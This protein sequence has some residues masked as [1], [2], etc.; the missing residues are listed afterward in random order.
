[1]ELSDC[2]PTGHS[3][4]QSVVVWC[5]LWSAG[6]TEPDGG[7][8]KHGLGICEICTHEICGETELEQS[9]HKV[10]IVV[11]AFLLQRSHHF[12]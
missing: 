10:Y 5:L 6:H 12:M 1:M 7:G 9:C 2:C 8:G 4:Y 3:M 11:G